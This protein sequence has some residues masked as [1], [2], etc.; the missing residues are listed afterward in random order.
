MSRKHQVLGPV[1]QEHVRKLGEGKKTLGESL[2]PIPSPGDGQPESAQ[3]S[4]G[5]L[6]ET[7]L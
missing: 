7:V 4:H 5:C 1:F 2:M 6:K 3:F